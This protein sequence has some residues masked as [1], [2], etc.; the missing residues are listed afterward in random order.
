[1]PS[2]AEIYRND[3]KVDSLV[4][5]ILQNVCFTVPFNMSKYAQLSL[6]RYDWIMPVE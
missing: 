1:M 4:N 5:S 3:L 2:E 6:H